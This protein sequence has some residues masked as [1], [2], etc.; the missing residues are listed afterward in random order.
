MIEILHSEVT[1][2][3]KQGRAILMLEVVTEAQPTTVSVLDAVSATLPPIEAR[4]LGVMFGSHRP[5]RLAGVERC[6]CAVELPF[7]VR[8]SGAAIAKRCMRAV[9]LG[10]SLRI[11]VPRGGDFE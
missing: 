2:M 6:T 4:P 7:S 8:E 9:E 5:G 11:F 10:A 3:R 1:A